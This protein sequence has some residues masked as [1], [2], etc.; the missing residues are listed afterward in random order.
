MSTINKNEARALAEAFTSFAVEIAK[1]RY[2]QWETLSP[3]ARKN[4]VDREYELMEAGGK[5]RA[6]AGILTLDEAQG[7]VSDLTDAVAV[8][9]KF[10]KRVKAVKKGINVIGGVLSFAAAIVSKDPKAI[11]DQLKALK[12]MLGTEEK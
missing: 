2:D 12:K 1:I 3:D 10:L 11:F 5:M 6:L 4:L 7:A 8:A 9:E